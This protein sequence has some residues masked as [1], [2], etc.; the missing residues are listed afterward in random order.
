MTN[1]PK[2][3]RKRNIGQVYKLV[4]YFLRESAVEFS[5]SLK[6]CVA[7]DSVIPL[8]GIHIEEIIECA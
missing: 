3:S 1:S 6:M 7:F 8:Q 4:Q 5:R 2:V